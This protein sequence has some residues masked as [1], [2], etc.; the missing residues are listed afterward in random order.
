MGVPGI[1]LSS[2]RYF[3]IYPLLCLRTDTDIYRNVST[4]DTA[5]SWSVV[6]RDHTASDPGVFSRRRHTGIHVARTGGYERVSVSEP[7]MDGLP[8]SSYG[9]AYSDL[10]LESAGQ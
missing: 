10:K 8:S 7:G 3:S 2:Y 1:R 4:A 5:D 9:L 6:Q